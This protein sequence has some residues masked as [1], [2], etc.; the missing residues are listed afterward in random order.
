MDEYRRNRM[1]LLTLPTYGCDPIPSN[2]QSEGRTV[3]TPVFRI[4]TLRTKRR[5]RY[6]FRQGSRSPSVTT[7]VI[8]TAATTIFHTV[9]AAE[10]R[11][12]LVENRTHFP[13]RI[14]KWGA[15]TNVGGRCARQRLRAPPERYNADHGLL[16]DTEDF[17]ELGPGNVQDD[18]IFARRSFRESLG[19][20]SRRHVTNRVNQVR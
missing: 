11:Y 9:W 10:S 8:A 7:V 15:A 13:P 18:V 2:L 1:K 17:S 20:G 14:T 12:Q 16:L 3:S 5:C 4:R 19:H 6:R